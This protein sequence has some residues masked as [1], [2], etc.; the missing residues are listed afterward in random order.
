MMMMMTIC[1]VKQKSITALGHFSVNDKHY[2]MLSFHRDLNPITA[3]EV[4]HANHYTIA[5][6]YPTKKLYITVNNF[7]NLC[8]PT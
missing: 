5:N 6:Y 3:T 2:E 7:L 4:K 1:E 8:Y